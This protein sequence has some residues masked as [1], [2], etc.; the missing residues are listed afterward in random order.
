MGI[1]PAVGVLFIF[2]GVGQLAA[3]N[4]RRPRRDARSRPV[5]LGF[6]LLV[7]GGLLLAPIGK[8]PE[9]FLRE[10]REEARALVEKLEAQQRIVARIQTDA[11]GRPFVARTDLEPAETR[12]T[13]AFDLAT[14]ASLI[15][16]PEIGPHTPHCSSARA[17]VATAELRKCIAFEL[18][19][20]VRPSPESTGSGFSGDA[21][22]Y[23]LADGRYLGGVALQVAPEQRS[24][25]GRLV[26]LRVQGAL[27]GHVLE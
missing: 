24:K 26:A 20:V 3:A 23:D 15:G 9:W 10:Y 18:I 8:A 7:A 12:R 2:V 27:T 1:L 6:A 14:G 19:A 22:V 21:L 4:A 25:S 17:A 11:A 16:L 13:L 5:W